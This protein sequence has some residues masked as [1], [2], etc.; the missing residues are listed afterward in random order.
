MDI[1]GI[2]SLFG[3]RCLPSNVASGNGFLVQINLFVSASLLQGSWRETVDCEWKFGDNIL[4][5]YCSIKV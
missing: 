2:C 1:Q 5:F 3:L 4:K